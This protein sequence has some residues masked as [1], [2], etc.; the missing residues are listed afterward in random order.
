M[1]TPAIELPRL[2]GPVDY[3]AITA[4]LLAKY[5]A[6]PAMFTAAAE[7]LARSQP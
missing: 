6:F 2:V 3:R 7:Q 5:P 1:N 4:V